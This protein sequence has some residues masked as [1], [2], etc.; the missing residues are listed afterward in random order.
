MSPHTESLT[1]KVAVIG[2]GARNLGGL[3]S[4]TFAGH[5]ANVVVNYHSDGS[6]KDAEA[7]VA[8]VGAAGFKGTVSSAGW[9]I[10][11]GWR[12]LSSRIGPWV[13]QT[14]PAG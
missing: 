4:R 10:R 5:G 6:R 7:T 9:S 3:V 11:M 1:G 2:D 12:D 8:A 13:G 14:A